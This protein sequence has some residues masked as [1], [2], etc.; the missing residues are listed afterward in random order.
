MR[1]ILR[2]GPYAAVAL[3]S[4][5]G[6]WLTFSLLLSLAGTASLPGMMAARIV[7]GL[8]SLLGNRHWTWKANRHLALARNGRRF[9]LLYAVSYGAS[10]ALFT[11]ATRGLGLPPYPAKLSS[12]TACFILNF[13]VMNGYV[14]HARQGLGQLA[15]QSF[16][17]LH[18]ARRS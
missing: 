15:R 7:G 13:V 8:I 4:A 11:L 17:A 3:L 12:D 18:R 9:L 16:G 1:P 14:F 2:F 5:A 10:V 6:D